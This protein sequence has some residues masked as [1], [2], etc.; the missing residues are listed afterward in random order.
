[1]ENECTTLNQQTS[2]D[3]PFQGAAISVNFLV[4]CG[5][6]GTALRVALIHGKSSH[7][8]L[9]AETANAPHACT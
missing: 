7:S 9:I 3:H 8:H 5:G 1:M 4:Q 2:H 6:A